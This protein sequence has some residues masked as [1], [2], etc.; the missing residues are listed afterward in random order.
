MLIE[1]P[2]AALILCSFARHETTVVGVREKESKE[3]ERC[4]KRI[5]QSQHFIH[6]TQSNKLRAAVIPDAICNRR[7]ISHRL[8]AIRSRTAMLEIAHAV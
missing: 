7:T 8:N 3:N 2:Y 6:E 1:T 5:M 4:I